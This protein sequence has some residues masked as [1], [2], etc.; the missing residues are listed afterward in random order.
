MVY[1]TPSR[2]LPYTHLLVF[3]LHARIHA[4]IVASR[5]G[6]GHF[7]CFYVHC[8]ESVLSVR[9]RLTRFS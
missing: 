3:S 9:F 7:L 5:P 4:S 2:L 6:N 8:Q 1:L